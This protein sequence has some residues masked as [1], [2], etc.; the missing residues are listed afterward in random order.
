MAWRQKHIS[1]FIWGVPLGLHWGSWAVPP[2]LGKQILPLVAFIRLPC[3]LCTPGNNLLCVWITHSRLWL[4]H[5]ELWVQ[6]QPRYALSLCIIQKQ[7]HSPQISYFHN[8]FQYANVSQEAMIMIYKMKQLFRTRPTGFK[9]SPSL[10]LI[11]TW[12]VAL[13][14]VA[15]TLTL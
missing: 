14:L 3:W 5:S 8:L 15:R 11:F 2:F 7:K 6:H 4:F 10:T 1:C 13:R 9:F 12:G